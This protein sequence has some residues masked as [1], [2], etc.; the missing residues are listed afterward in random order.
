[1]RAYLRELW[2]GVRLLPEFLRLV[3]SVE[4][5]VGVIQRYEAKCYIERHFDEWA[6]WA[7]EA[8]KDVKD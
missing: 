7:E 2:E 4:Y 5:W 8:K 1:M 6:A 3:F